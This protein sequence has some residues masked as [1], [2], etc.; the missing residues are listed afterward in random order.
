ML[1]LT[2]HDAKTS[3]GETLMKAQ[4][5]PV[6]ITKSGKPVAV[7]M[8][9]ENFQMTENLK[10]KMLLERVERADQ[11]IAAGELID[12]EEFMKDVAAGKYD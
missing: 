2:A 1:T 8:S 10:M 6:Q 3:F 7:I 5:A 4:Q 11:E 12:G 9:I